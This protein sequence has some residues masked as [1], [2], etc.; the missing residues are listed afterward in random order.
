[1]PLPAALRSGFVY[2]AHAFVITPAFQAER[3]AC[4]GVDAAIYGGEVGVAILP[5]CTVE[6][7]RR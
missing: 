4:C 3:L 5:D 7:V 6:A 1:M 2:P